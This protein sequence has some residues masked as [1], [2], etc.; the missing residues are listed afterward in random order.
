MRKTFKFDKNKS[1]DSK[2]KDELNQ[3]N[4]LN[5]NKNNQEFNQNN[6]NKPSIPGFITPFGFMLVSA[7]TGFP[8]IV[9]LPDGFMLVPIPGFPPPEFPISIPPVLELPNI[10][11]PIPNKFTTNQQINENLEHLK[12]LQTLLD[13]QN[14]MGHNLNRLLK[15]GEETRMVIKAFIQM[16]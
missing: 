8:Q 7:P 6:Q 2:K 13:N 10:I 16:E 15:E 3:D 14:I 1:L 4:G 9:G 12:A 11:K 5:N